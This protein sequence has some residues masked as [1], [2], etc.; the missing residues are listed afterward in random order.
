MDYLMMDLIRLED[1]DY[2]E[3]ILDKYRVLDYGKLPL[4]VSEKVEQIFDK[5][6][7][8]LKKLHP[9]PNFEDEWI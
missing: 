2:V 3:K 6:L 8:K 7:K 5:R 4:S 9:E 1:Y